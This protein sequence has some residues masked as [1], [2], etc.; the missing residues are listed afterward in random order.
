MKDKQT[1]LNPK[2]EKF[3]QLVAQGLGAPRAYGE[4]G[5]LGAG[6]HGAEAN[7]SALLKKPHVAARVAEI[8]EM[9]DGLGVALLT[10]VRKR[11]FLAEVVETPIGSI[12]PESRLCQEFWEKLEMPREGEDGKVVLRRRVRMVDKLRAI[13]LDSKLAN[14]FAAAKDGDEDKAVS[15]AAV[16]AK[17]AEML[18]GIAERVRNVIPKIYGTEAEAREL[19]GRVAGRMGG[20]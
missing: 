7:G 11:T 8:R 19:I 1:R 18:R 20:D 10:I 13:E 3:A 6:G 2:Q 16:S 9:A 5:Y 15:D 17:A 4:A 12:G 14:H